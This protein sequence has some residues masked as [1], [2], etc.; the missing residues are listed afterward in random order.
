M[1]KIKYIYLVLVL[2]VFGSGCKPS[3]KIVEKGNHKQDWV[4]YLF[5]NYIGEKPSASF[6]VIKDGKVKDCQSFGYADLENKVL[7]K[8]ETNYRLASVTK[9]F[10]AMGVLILIHRG[11]LAYNTKLTEIL[12]EFPDYGKEITVKDLL[13]HRSGLQDYSNLYPEHEKK[14]LVDKDVL[15][16]LMKQDSLLFP[17]NSDYKYSN[18]GYAVLAMI[19]ERV[20]GK[21]FKDFMDNEIFQRIGMT[22]STVYLNNIHI[23]N[24]AFGYKFNDTIFQNKDQ[25]K[26]SAIQGDGGIYSSVSDYIHWDRSLYDETLITTALRNDAFL[27]WGENGKTEEKG[28]GFGWQIDIK[29]NRKYLMHGGS[30]TGFRNYAVRFPS[31]KISVVIYTNTADYGTGELKRKAFFLLSLYSDGQLPLPIDMII[32]REIDTNGS[33]R[34]KEYYNTLSA[35]QNKYE[36]NTTDLTSLGFR[37]LS[38]K[39]NANSLNVFTF[40][41][42]QF[43][44]YFGGYFGLAQYHKTNGNNEKA[45]EYFKR[46]PELATSEN[47]R[48][49]DYAKKMIKQLAE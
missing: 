39:E 31:E 49:I 33:K 24:R 4:K 9:Q 16:L 1:K 21:T 36:T 17:A 37:Y 42:T 13:A 40:I 32:E 14:Q 12:P 30:T 18:S 34:I 45:I 43:P 46:I 6:I 10:T 26:W 22:N 29:N 5:R 28:Y 19:I 7:A 38:K 27:N 44:D 35:V 48:Q 11:Q 23:K 8:C 25:N 3:E 41:K 20:S 15:N 2:F 47:Q